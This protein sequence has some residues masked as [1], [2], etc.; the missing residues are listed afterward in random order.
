MTLA[1]PVRASRHLL[2]LFGKSCSL[3]SGMAK[4]RSRSPRWAT[5]EGAAWD[6]ISQGSNANCML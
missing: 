3:S 4:L 1:G 6:G 5:Q 2:E